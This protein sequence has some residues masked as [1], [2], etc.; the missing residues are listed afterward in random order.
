MISL[1]RRDIVSRV[2]SVSM[3]PGHTEFTRMPISAYSIAA[4]READH[5]VLGRDVA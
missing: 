5:A 2:M 4:V 1:P 3:K